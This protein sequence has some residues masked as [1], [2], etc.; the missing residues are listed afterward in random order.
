MELGIYTFGDL[1][2][3]WDTGLVPSGGERID[4]MLAIARLAD[5]VGLDV[6][7]VGEHHGLK[8]VNSATAATLAAMAAVTRNIRLTSA[9]TLLAAADPV[10]TLQEFATVDL[11]SKG[12]AE[13]MFGRGVSMDHYG[14]FGLERADNDAIFAEKP[15]LFAQLNAQ[16]R[17]TWQGQFRAPLLEAEIAPRPVQPRLP[18][19][20]AAGSIPSVERAARLGYPLALPL[21][22]RLEGA[23]AH[24][25]GL[26]AAYRQAW[27]EAGRPVHEARTATFSFLTVSEKQADIDRDYFGAFDRYMR[28]HFKQPLSREVYRTMLAPGGGLVAGTVQQ[29]TEKILAIHEATGDARH[30]GH[31]DLGG[32]PFG[33]IANAIELLGTRVAPAIRKYTQASPTP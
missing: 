7:G 18:V 1:S 29:V 6:I 5:E 20:I 8:Y 12:R 17:V 15:D 31:I 9:A 11:I 19:W 28:P 4:T 13:I 21:V 27:T 32:Q 14:L 16:E 23:I 22:A 26:V 24:N 2:A 33:R 3:D 10:R 25:A 30:L